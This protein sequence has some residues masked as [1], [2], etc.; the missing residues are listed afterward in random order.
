LVHS[1]LY[2]IAIQAEVLDTTRGEV[3]HCLLI[4]N[5]ARSSLRGSLRGSLLDPCMGHSETT[6]NV[7][8][9]NDLLAA[10]ILITIS[11]ADARRVEGE[12]GRQY[13]SVQSAGQTFG[14]ILG[15]LLQIG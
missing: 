7:L 2:R 11:L 1:H 4:I 8:G 6:L 12:V 3:I 9:I 14:D 13:T 10:V 15:L 5:T